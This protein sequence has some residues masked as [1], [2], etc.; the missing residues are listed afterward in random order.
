VVEVPL[1]DDDSPLSAGREAVLDEPGTDLHRLGDIA[2]RFSRALRPGDLVL[3]IGPLGAGKTT[4]VR[5]LADGLGVTDAVRSPSFTI[6]NR[7]A[8]P[9]PVHHLDLYRLER[10]TDE[11]ALVLEDYLTPDA[12]TMVEWP[13]TGLA[14]LGEPTWVVRLAHASP[15]TRDVRLEASPAAAVRWRAAGGSPD[16]DAAS[17]VSGE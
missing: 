3:L 11:D 4:L 16:D 5:L 1:H 15:D 9:L 7:Y 14:R 17:G 8:G 13:D 12:V 10:L 2:T 6:A